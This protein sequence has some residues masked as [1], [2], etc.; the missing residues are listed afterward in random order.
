LSWWED[1]PD[2]FRMRRRRSPFFGFAGGIFEEMNRLFED[3]FREIWEQVPRELIRERKLPDGTT[4]R[5][6][7][8]FVY[9]Y[10][11]TMG[12]DGKP[13]IREFGNVRPKAGAFPGRAAF[14]VKE[15]REPLVDTIVED[16]TIKVVAEVPGVE[17]DDI[18]LQ[19]TENSLVISVD[20]EKRKY[21]KELDLPEAVDPDSA[22]A[23]YKNG[24]LEVALKK[25]V[26]KPKGKEIKID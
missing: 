2:W 4:V 23:S 6:A 17:K 13:I 20:S 1:F 26:T 8:P 15:E 10:S 7:G 24:V 14:E 3:M 19:C 9:G 5:E 11:V 12:P 21:Y 22:K 25:K 18:K 16:D